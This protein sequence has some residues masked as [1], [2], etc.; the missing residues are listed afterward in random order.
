MIYFFATSN[1]H[2]FEEAK[3]ILTVPLIA[4][5]VDI[6]E[7]QGSIE[8]IVIKKAI[9]AY[10]IIKPR[11]PEPICVITDDVSLEIKM[12][13]NFPGVYVKEFISNGFENLEKILNIHDKSATAI[14]AIGICY[15]SPGQTQSYTTKCFKAVVNGQLTFNRPIHNVNAFGFDKIFV[16]DG[17]EK[18]YAEC[19]FTDKNKVSH[20]RKA[21]KKL[22]DFLK[23][24][25]FCNSI[26]KKKI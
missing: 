16:P 5:N 9:D 25:D 22:E 15:D 18:T 12:L 21:L 14:C 19:N 17:M 10:G 6:T 7:I 23:I 11:Y 13:N 26:N 20:R 2:K 4:E 8:D 24:Q 3:D 1:K